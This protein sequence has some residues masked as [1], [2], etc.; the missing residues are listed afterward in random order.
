ML[1]TRDLLTTR[2]PA[3]GLLERIDAA[4]SVC[5]RTLGPTVRVN[6]L[7]SRSKTD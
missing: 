4:R 2:E 5:R 6:F 1:I 3:V 7:S